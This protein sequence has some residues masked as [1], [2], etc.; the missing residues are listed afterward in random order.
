LDIWKKKT[1]TILK[2]VFQKI[3]R[4]I[5]FKQSLTINPHIRGVFCLRGD[6]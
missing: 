4:I 6:G 1:K 3:F 5:L 2:I